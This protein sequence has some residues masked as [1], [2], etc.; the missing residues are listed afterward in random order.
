MHP[1]LAAEFIREFHAEINR[2]RHDAEL[3][4]AL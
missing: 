3:S 2:Q 4:F 1:D